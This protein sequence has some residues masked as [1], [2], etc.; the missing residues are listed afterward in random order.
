MQGI[1]ISGLVFSVQMWCVQ[2]G[3]AVLTAVYQPAQTLIVAILTLLFLHDS[4]YLG[5]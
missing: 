2:R 4:F 5:R 1:V 3:G